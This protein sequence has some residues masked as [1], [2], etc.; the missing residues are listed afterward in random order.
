MGRLVEP[1]VDAAAGFVDGLRPRASRDD[2]EP[3]PPASST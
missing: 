3:A 2:L 1:G